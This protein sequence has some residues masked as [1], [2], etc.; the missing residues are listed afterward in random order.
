M[1]FYV[2]V[3]RQY[4]MGYKNSFS[5]YRQ[6]R[7]MMM[8]TRLRLM[9]RVVVWRWFCMRIKSIIPQLRKFM[10]LRWRPSSK[11]KIHNH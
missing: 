8:K 5:Y 10:V 2:L 7:R 9:R 11:K 6:M 1:M 3:A 4:M